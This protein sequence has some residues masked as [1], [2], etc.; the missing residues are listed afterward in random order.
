VRIAGIVHSGKNAVGKK[1]SM[2]PKRS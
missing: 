2:R 1:M